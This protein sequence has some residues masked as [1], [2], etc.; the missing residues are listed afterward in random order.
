MS[1]APGTTPAPAK[2]AWTTGLFDVCAEPGGGATCIYAT[3]CPACAFGEM[4]AGAPRGSFPC[5]GNCVGACLLVSCL[6]LLMN[7]L[8]HGGL[9]AAY[10]IR[11][12]ACEDCLAAVLCTHCT[13]CQQSREVRIRNQPQPA[14]AAQQRSPQQAP[15][16]QQMYQVQQQP[17]MVYVMPQQQPQQM[18]PQ[19]VAIGQPPQTYPLK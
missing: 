12:T 18:Q 8:A 6:P 19:F 17:Q 5:A 9:R 3:L 11:G 7:C 1:V 15:P 2:D 14:A 13:I 16:P 10:G 4:A